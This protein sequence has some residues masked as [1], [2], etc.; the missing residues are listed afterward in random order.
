VANG[1]VYYGTGAGNDVV[2]L[3]ARTGRRLRGLSVHGAIFNAPSVVNGAVYAG[4]WHGRLYSFGL[5]R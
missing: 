4:S 5:P 3:N 1:V 2:A